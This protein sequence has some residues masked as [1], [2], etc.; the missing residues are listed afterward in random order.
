MLPGEEKR[1]GLR[2]YLKTL[3]EVR[4]GR[5]GSFLSEAAARPEV[6][7]KRQWSRRTGHRAGRCFASAAASEM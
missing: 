4:P 1:P 2:L 3:N 7:L 5:A 6:H